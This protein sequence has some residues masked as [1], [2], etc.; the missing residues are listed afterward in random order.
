M[1]WKV[2]LV[3]SI[4]TLFLLAVPSLA[5]SAVVTS[6]IDNLIT[7]KEQGSYSLRITNNADA[8]QRY[9]IYSLQ[10][11]QGWNVDPSPLKDKIIELQPG[12]SH[13]T[14]I[15]VT[16]LEDFTPGIYNVHISIQSDLGETYSIPFKFYVAPEG[17]VNYLPTIKATLDMNEKINP[18]E[19]VSIKLFLEN[20]NPLDLTGLKI[21]IQ[22][23]IPEFTKEVMV[24]LPPLEKKTVEFSV[25]PSRSQQPK[26]YVLFFVFERAG[27]TVKVIEK[28]IEIL[29]LLPE[30][31]VTTTE[32]KAFLKTAKTLQ[33]INEGNV[34]NTQ[35][36]H[37]PISLVGSLFT[38]SEG[39]AKVEDGKRFLTWEVSLSP[40]ES[41]ELSL[42]TNYRLL[43][44]LL[45]AVLTFLAFYFYVQSPLSIQKTA[46]TTKM[47]DSGALSEIKITLELKN[48]S[49]NPVAEVEVID[50]IPSIANI[51]KG[52][53]IGTL[54]PKEMK[55]TKTGTSV[56]WSLAELDGHEHRL[57]T[58]KMKA[59][60]N[61]LG[62][63]SLPRAT[64]QFKKKKSKKV[65]KAYSNIFRISG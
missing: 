49:K 34:R 29:A 31:A 48:N 32:E 3:V 58:Y 44:Y 36:V 21:K 65:K 57:I 51:D 43:L 5:D 41:T 56:M 45:L 8:V 25:M 23:D 62:T 18:R 13:T 55:H 50:I 9:S 33:V 52:L 11:G 10:S 47:G 42:V 12:Q 26:E 60:L 24:D 27:E 46:V 63:L 40:E 20:R 53:E 59:K 17:P 39:S 61:I 7:V 30:F 37:Y 28:Q 38:T 1:R 64:V 16:P 54:K 19:P 2:C 14:K 6:A 15:V 22:S 35:T 4:I